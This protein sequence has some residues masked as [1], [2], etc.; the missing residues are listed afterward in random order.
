MYEFTMKG[1]QLYVVMMIGTAL[2]TAKCFGVRFS[3]QNIFP[4]EKKNLSKKT[5]RLRFTEIDKII[6]FFIKP[7]QNTLSPFRKLLPARAPASIRALE[8]GTHYVPT[9]ECH[10]CQLLLFEIVKIVCVHMHHDQSSL[11]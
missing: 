5:C 4:K 8:L 7:W 1:M 10:G 6:T 11:L 3:K 9:K 2:K